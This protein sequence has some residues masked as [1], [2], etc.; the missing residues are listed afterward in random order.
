MQHDDFNSTLNTEVLLN[1]EIAVNTELVLNHLYQ[2]QAAQSQAGTTT[3][4]GYPTMTPANHAN[5]RH[6]GTA[7]ESHLIRNKTYD[8]DE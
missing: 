6:P 3:Y 8:Y 5:R 4:L 7:G 1:T 2:A